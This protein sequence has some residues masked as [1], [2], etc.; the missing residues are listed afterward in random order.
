M[1]SP[2]HSAVAAL[3]QLFARLEEENELNEDKET[4]ASHTEDLSSACVKAAPV[5]SFEIPA[6]FEKTRCKL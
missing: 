5:K 2:H 6:E 4:E 1:R 3:T